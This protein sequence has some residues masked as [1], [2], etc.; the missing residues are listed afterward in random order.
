MEKKRLLVAALPMELPPSLAHSLKRKMPAFIPMD[1]ERLVGVTGVGKSNVTRFYRRLERMA[2]Q[3]EKML[4]IG[5]AGSLCESLPP[6]KIVTFDKVI[7]YQGKVFSLFPVGKLH[8]SIGLEVREW[9]DAGEKRRLRVAHPHAEIIDMETATHAEEC[10]RLGVKLSVLRIVTDGPEDRLPSLAYIFE[11][12]QH[13]VWKKI[14]SH[15][16]HGLGG[17]MFSWRLWKARESLTKEVEKL[18]EWHDFLENA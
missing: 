15:P 9:T 14:L 6:G 3:I 2:I 1:E 8:R 10:A 18:E 16:L 17:L 7:T 5:F 12:W 11:D 13:V 4:L